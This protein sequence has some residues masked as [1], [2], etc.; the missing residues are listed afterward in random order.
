MYVSFKVHK[1]FLPMSRHAFPI[2]SFI[3]NKRINKDHNVVNRFYKGMYTRGST[4][5]WFAWCWYI[6]PFL[7]GLSC[8]EYII[9]T[10]KKTNKQK[11]TKTKEITSYNV[12]DLLWYRFIFF[13]YYNL[14]FYFSRAKQARSRAQKLNDFK[15]KYQ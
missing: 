9:C 14:L 12:F 3:S 13:F 8:H 1:T 11:N 7:I 15:T 5:S 4:N 2:C 6:C 10:V